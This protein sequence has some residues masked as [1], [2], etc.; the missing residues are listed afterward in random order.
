[1]RDDGAAPPVVVINEAMA[2][3]FWPDGDPMSD[4]LVIGKGVM[5]EFAA[6]QPRQIIG[7]VA[8]TRDNGLNRDPGP[9]DVRAAGAGAGRGQR[10][11][12]AA[13]ADRL[14]RP[15]AVGDPH[16]SAAPVQDQLRQV[17]GLPVSDVR[18]MDEIVTL[19]T[20]RQRFNMV[21]MV[22]FGGVRAAAGGDRHLRF[23][24]VLGGAAHAGDRHP[25]RAR[26]RDRGGQADDR[27]L[28]GCGWHSWASSSASRRR[29]A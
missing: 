1:M 23:D 16:A 17:T 6:E 4:R 22:V 10:V 29:S 8:N 5:R 7:I 3:Q 12:R 21:L 11:E 19:S 26:R 2:K 13:D 28:R 15:H 18:T 20:S 25:P 14:D 24:G 9:T 27:L